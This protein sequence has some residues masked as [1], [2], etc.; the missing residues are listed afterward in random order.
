VTEMAPEEVPVCAWSDIPVAEC[1]HCR[2]EHLPEQLEPEFRP[3]VVAPIGVRVWPPAKPGA[4]HYGDPRRRA[5]RRPPL[6]R[7]HWNPDKRA[8]F[9]PEHT[10]DCRAASCP[11]CR[12]CGETHCALRGSCPNHVNPATGIR[13]CPRCIGLTRDTITEILALTPLVDLEVEY[14]GVDSEAAYLAGPIA[15]VELDPRRDAAALDPRRGHAVTLDPTDEL[16]PFAV[17]GR[18]DL[19]LR[20]TYGPPETGR[21][22]ITRSGAYLLHLLDGKF[23][24][25][26]PFEDA[27]RELSKCLSHLEDVISDSRAPE[28]GAPCPKCTA[29]LEH[30]GADR[31]ASRLVKHY[32]QADKTGASDVWVCPD[33]GSHRWE[34][35]DY[36][37]TISDDYLANATRLTA[38]Q[39]LKQHG[40]KPGTLTAWA[41]L[42]KV[43]KRGHDQLGRVL[44]D[45]DDALAQKLRRATEDVS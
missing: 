1:A 22:T 27:A 40:I 17:L 37:L 25:D 34:E 36:R 31:K 15:P 20:P 10:I 6:G 28:T 21:I 7:C 44:Y 19:Q 45:V 4:L 9:T 5:R 42:G 30:T 14:S 2:G 23:P 13:T 11:G 43:R 26:E 38:P 3:Q 8:W 24:H 16:H 32:N 35:A 39:M 33:D 29:L 18:W 12:P 41:T